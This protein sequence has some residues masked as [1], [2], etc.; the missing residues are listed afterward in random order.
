MKGCDGLSTSAA[1]CEDDSD[2]QLDDIDLADS[3]HE[4]NLGSELPDQ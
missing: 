2:E 4:A 1:D 3:L